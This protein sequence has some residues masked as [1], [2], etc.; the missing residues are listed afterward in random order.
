MI[1]QINLDDLILKALEEDFDHC[2]FL[3]C[4]IC[5]CTEINACP[6]GCSWSQHFI[7]Q[8]RLVCSNCESIA[9]VSQIQSSILTLLQS[10]KI[11]KPGGISES[12][13]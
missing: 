5:G 6:G 3:S 13:N 1:N 2:L 12:T 9:I 10:G 4:E 8:G 7:N 11:I